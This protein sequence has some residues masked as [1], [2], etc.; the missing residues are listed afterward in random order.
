MR[1]AACLVVW[2]A[3][4]PTPVATTC[5]DHVARGE[6][7]ITEIFASAATADAGQEWLEL[8]NASARPI[9]LAGI[10]I[11]NAHADGAMPRIHRM[12]ALA[13]APGQYLALGDVDPE[14]LPPYLDDGYGG[15]LG[16]L[17]DAGGG[18]L[19]LACDAAVIDAVAYAGALAGH[20]REL[21]ANTPPDA[22]VNDDPAR[23]CDGTATEFAPGSFG[24][25]GQASDCIALGLGQCADGTIARAIVSPPPGALRITEIMANPIVEPA[26]EW[27]EI[28]NTGAASF[29][30]IGLAIDRVA[31]SRAPDMIGGS[32]C[33][34]LAPGAFALFARSADAASNG[35]LPAVD[36]TF[37]LSLVNSS[38]DVRVMFGASVLDAATWSTTQNGASMQMFPTA[39]AGTTPY[40]DGA[41]RGTPGAAN[42]CL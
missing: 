31:D 18:R 10:E 27:L 20:A 17:Y 42:S 16:A 6:L 40:G 12:H 38:G 25:P 5:R 24:T 33:R 2:A 26:Q 39:C 9:D 11:A 22:A 1:A 23:W 34:P 29:D 28:E 14:H 4:G 3:C 35:G 41:N 30:R 13:I 32:A 19:S 36:A 21:G 15:D 7:V 37:G 8:Y